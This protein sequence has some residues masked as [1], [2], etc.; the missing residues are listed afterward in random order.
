[1][2]SLAHLTATPGKNEADCATCSTTNFLPS[3]VVE[4]GDSESLSQLRRD[5]KLWLEDVFAV[6]RCLGSLVFTHSPEFFR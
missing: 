1:M 6:S 4:V 3:T 5:A 2:L